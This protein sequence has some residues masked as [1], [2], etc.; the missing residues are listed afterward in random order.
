VIQEAAGKAGEGGH[1]SDMSTTEFA[2]RRFLGAAQQINDPR[3]R[4][5]MVRLW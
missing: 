1:S 5:V 3:A 2:A 4:P